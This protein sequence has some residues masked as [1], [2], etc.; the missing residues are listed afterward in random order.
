MFYIQI[1][2]TILIEKCEDDDYKSNYNQI[3][4]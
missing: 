1:H 4:N 3:K 2:G